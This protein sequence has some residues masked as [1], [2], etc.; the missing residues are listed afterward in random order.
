MEQWVAHFTLSPCTIAYLIG[1]R[2]EKWFISKSKYYLAWWEKFTLL[3]DRCL[4][5]VSQM[6]DT[7]KYYSEFLKTTKNPHLAF[8]N[9]S[10]H[11]INTIKDYLSNKIFNFIPQSGKYK[12]I[13][14]KRTNDQLI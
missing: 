13:Q 1:K 11:L 12:M 7:A 14:L 4:T 5:H 10:T 6:S 2:T 8:I 3:S 9:F